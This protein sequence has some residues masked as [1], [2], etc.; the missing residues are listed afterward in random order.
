MSRK[1]TFSPP[2][3]H[4]PSYGSLELTRS[5]GSKTW[6]PLPTGGYI[7]VEVL[8][9]G[10]TQAQIRFTADKTIPIIKGESIGR[11]QIS[12]ND[13]DDDIES[14]MDDRYAGDFEDNFNK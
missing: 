8:D 13:W 1:F 5:I 10:R 6:L 2:Q 7:C 12:V 14:R 9:T 11:P 4:P 3:I